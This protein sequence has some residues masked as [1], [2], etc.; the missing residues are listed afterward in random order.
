VTPQHFH[1]RVSR[2]KYCHRPVL[3]AVSA[4]TGRRFPL[5]HLPD[6]ERGNV[7]IDADDQAHVLSGVEAAVL[8]HEGAEDL[9]TS[10]HYTSPRCA[11]AARAA[12]REGP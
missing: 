9:Y 5:D 11:E 4:T 6:A 3:W 2:C 7:L 1:S 12:R 10:H 8:R